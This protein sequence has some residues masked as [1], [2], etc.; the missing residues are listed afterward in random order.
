V[1]VG[2][3]G[4]LRG[5][6]ATAGSVNVIPWSPGIGQFNAALE[7]SIGNY[8]ERT[9]EGVV[10]IP[11]TQNSAFRLAGILSGARQLFHQCEPAQ[12]TQLGTSLPI[13]ESEGVGVAE[14]AENFGLRAS[15]LI[16]PTDRLRVTLTADWL[17]ENGSGYTGVNYANPLGNG[18]NPD[19]ISNP[20]DVVGRA[21]TP[22]LDTDHYGFKAHRGIRHRLV[23]HRVY[24]RLSRP[25][26]RLSRR[27]PA[28]AVL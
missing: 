4:T 18:I 22:E 7:A 25:G 23:Q 21:F 13:A 1:N 12:F 24:R 28:L 10:N 14:A 6:N 9:L 16:E 5:R 11:V 27:D 17:G 26:L 2:P 3:Q 8:G 15:Y 20:R 19:D